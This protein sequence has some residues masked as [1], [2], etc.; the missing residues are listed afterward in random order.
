MSSLPVLED[1]EI[2]S[3]K[4]KDFVL[5]VLH[6]NSLFRL[7]EFISIPSKD[8]RNERLIIIEGST[9]QLHIVWTAQSQSNMAP[10][11]EPAGAML[12]H[13]WRVDRSPFYSLVSTTPAGASIITTAGQI[14]RRPDGSFPSDP[15]EQIEEA[16]RNLGRC[17][18][19]AG[20]RVEDITKLTYFI[21]DFD[22]NNPRHR[23][24]VFD[25]LGSRRPPTTL[26]PV[27][28]LV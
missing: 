20:A 9:G 14:G 28:K 15:V 21:V 24:P 18:E 25:F 2:I 16:V 11:S 12:L 5:L 27:E 17:L 26:V 6:T 10:K 23:K 22:H 13:P 1:R 7:E 4:R 3:W 8:P 19:A